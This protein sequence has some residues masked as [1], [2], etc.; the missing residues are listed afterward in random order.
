MSLKD[1]FKE[2]KYK[3]LSNYQSS[4][5]TSSGVESVEYADAYLEK[6]QRFTPLVDYSKPEEFARFGSAEKYYYD[7][8][9]TI[10]NTYPYD[11]SKKEKVLWELSSSAIDLHIFDN[12]YPRTTG[13]AVF[14]TAS[15][16]ATDTD[17]DYSIW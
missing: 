7:S 16:T 13:F 6:T 17:S 14:S 5:L 12:N 3:H 10:Y 9:T 8:I 1:L 2:Q 11:G 4:F 15:L